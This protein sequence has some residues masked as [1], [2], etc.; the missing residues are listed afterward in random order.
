MCAPTSEPFSMTATEHSGLRCLSRIA[1]ARPG[2]DDDHVVFH[3]FAFAHWL[4]PAVGV[5]CL[6]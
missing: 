3:D 1:Q 2:A 5:N 6:L 4:Q